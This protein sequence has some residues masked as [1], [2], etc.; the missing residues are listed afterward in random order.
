[1][2]VTGVN[3]S[4]VLRSKFQDKLPKLKYIKIDAEG[5]DLYI[6]QSIEDI[7]EKYRPIIKAEIFRHVDQSYR[8]KIHDYFLTKG[9]VV[10]KV[11]N[12]EDY[13]GQVLEKSD[14]SKWDHYDIYCVPSHRLKKSSLEKSE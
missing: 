7:V 4:N 11:N 8:N 5:F 10:H 14:M 2:T 12:E 1:M 6:L 13:M 9:Y 3:L